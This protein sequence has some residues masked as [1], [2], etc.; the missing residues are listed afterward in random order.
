MR[1]TAMGSYPRIVDECTVLFCVAPVSPMAGI[2]AEFGPQWVLS[3]RTTIGGD[4]VV[5]SKVN[6]APCC[7]CVPCPPS[8]ALA[9]A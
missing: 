7:R 2:A 5:G 9:I 6:L 4:V 1:L 3:A 8:P